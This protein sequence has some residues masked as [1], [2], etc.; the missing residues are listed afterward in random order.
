MHSSGYTSIKSSSTTNINTAPTPCAVECTCCAASARCVLC[1]AMLPLG[2]GGLLHV[3]MCTHNKSGIT[4]QDRNRRPE[5]V[6]DH[7]KAPHQQPWLLPSCTTLVILLC[8]VAVLQKFGMLECAPYTPCA[9][10]NLW[11]SSCL[12]ISRSALCPPDGPT[13]CTSRFQR[14]VAVVLLACAPHL[15]R[16]AH[17][18]CLLPLQVSVLEYDAAHDRLNTVAT[19]VHP[20]EVWDVACCPGQPN[21]LITVHSKGTQDTAAA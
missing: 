8:C 17:A 13:L 18:L 19:W 15:R 10:I 12:P 14:S 3:D 1:S 5:T 4:Y 16:P 11:L 20:E 6:V 9:A 7:K 21:R 2:E